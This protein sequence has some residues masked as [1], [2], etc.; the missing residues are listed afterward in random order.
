MGLNYPHRRLAVRIIRPFDVNAVWSNQTR[1]VMC[2]QYVMQTRKL[3]FYIPEINRSVT[4]PLLGT[5]TKII[6]LLSGLKLATTITSG[7]ETQ[8][9]FNVAQNTDVIIFQQQYDILA[10]LFLRLLATNLLGCLIEVVLLTFNR[11]QSCWK[12]G[13]LVCGKHAVQEIFAI[14]ST[15]K[16]A[17]ISRLPS[18]NSHHL[19][20]GNTSLTHT[21]CTQ[22]SH[23]NASLPLHVLPH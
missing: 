7:G 19:R 20:V 18:R 3:T 23:L 8:S 15:I 17:V 13:A 4:I 10:K 14:Q 9:I 16:P 1:N 6:Q 12:C 22:K 5:T 2:A 21:Y 11:T